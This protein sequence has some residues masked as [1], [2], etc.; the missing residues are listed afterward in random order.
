VKKA[1][2]YMVMQLFDNPLAGYDPE[3]LQGVAEIMEF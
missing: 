3:S 1:M 2:G